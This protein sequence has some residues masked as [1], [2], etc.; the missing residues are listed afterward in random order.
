MSIL[1]ALVLATAAW[2]AASPLRVVPQLDYERYAG[3]W[4]ELAR[5][6]FRYERDCVS[7]VT[8]SYAP[9]PDGRV[10]VTNRCV[11]ANGTF[12]EAEGVA[13]RVDGQPPSVLKVRFAPAFLS[14]LPMVWGDYQVIAL[15]ADYQYALV[16]T[17]DRAY[18]WLL[19][20]TPQMDPALY[21]ELVEQARS[22]GF[23]VA[24]LIKT[25]HTQ[26]AR[27]R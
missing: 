17:P 6:P 11:L 23:D 19:S 24:A 27:P 25:L 22:Q 15:G 13:R 7:D 5:L 26:S 3:R 8:A 4:F 18:L 16:G 9:R 12:Q 2:P 20:R 21:D 1:T 10:T 14:F